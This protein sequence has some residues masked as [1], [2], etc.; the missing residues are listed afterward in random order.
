MAKTRIIIESREHF[1]GENQ[2]NNRI[3]RAFRWRI[4]WIV[5]NCFVH[6]QISLQ[7][8]RLRP[9]CNMNQLDEVCICA[10]LSVC[11]CC[12]VRASLTVLGHGYIGPY[13]S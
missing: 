3:A 4:R 12:V 13:Y 8:E 7:E 11:M 9:S 2:D 6:L 5:I 10:S 1:V